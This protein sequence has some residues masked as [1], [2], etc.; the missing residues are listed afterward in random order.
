VIRKTEV[1]LLPR[2]ALLLR[3]RHDLPVIPRIAVTVACA[4]PVARQAYPADFDVV[5]ESTPVRN[6]RS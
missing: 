2:P 4:L 5:R 3:R 6:D 1:V